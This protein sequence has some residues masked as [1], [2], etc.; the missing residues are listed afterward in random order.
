MILAGWLLILAIAAVLTASLLA[1]PVIY[2]QQQKVFSDPGQYGL[3]FRDVS[4]ITEDGVRLKGWWIPTA[5]S[6]KTV[7]FLHG[8][9]G[10][11]DPD[12]KYAPAFHN[13]G[14]NVLLFDFRAHGR[15]GGWITSLGALEVRD[16]MAAV[17]FVRAQGSDD[18]GM[19]GFSMGGRAALLS[20]AGNPGAVRAVISDGGPLRLTTAIST[21]LA[22][23]G[24][25]EF[26][27]KTISYIIVFG[28]SVWARQWLFARDPIV[29]AGKLAPLPVLFIHGDQDPNTGP[30]ELE[31]TAHAAGENAAVWRIPEAGHRNAEDFIGDEYL[32][33]VIAFFE[34]NL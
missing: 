21:G 22:E 29:Q 24:L 14:F 20:A 32:R 12:L 5:D 28:M 6:E 11:C 2:R 3:A 9:A 16:C 26:L 34:S 30:D 25:P 7:I 33:R 17:R 31:R 1:F 4:F 23:K 13:A 8:Y 27:C 15:S 18:I 10:S 19:L